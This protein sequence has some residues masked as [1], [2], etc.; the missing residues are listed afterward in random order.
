M[1]EQSKYLPE[2]DMKIG[3]LGLG[4]FGMAL[5]H[6]T[7]QNIC[8]QHSDV[9]RVLMWG[10]NEDKVANWN[11]TAPPH[12]QAT[13]DVRHVLSTC[14]AIIYALPTQTFY[15][16]WKAHKDALSANKPI[17][18]TSKG[19]DKK[20]ALFLPELTSALLI[21]NPVAVLGGPH[22]AHELRKNSP[23]LALLG[24]AREATNVFHK[25]L[26]GNILMT[27]SSPD[28]L[29]VAI[30]GAF[31]NVMAVLGGCL[32]GQG[33]TQNTIASILELGLLEYETFGMALGA[34][35]KTLQHPALLADYRLT[36]GS[37]DSRNTKA[38]IAFGQYFIQDKTPTTMS[39]PKPRPRAS[40]VEGLATLPALLKR[41]QTEDIALPLCEALQTSLENSQP[42]DAQAL[43]KAHARK[44]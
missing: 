1:T 21:S 5:A 43:L 39:P 3:I 28:A 40:L 15:V 14:D 36:T 22:L 44:I 35:L 27:Q 11:N 26:G 34:D 13:T 30:A 10:R 42:I 16:F 24:G 29:A 37:A 31:K 4:A 20:T 18:I 8:P 12:T 2:L 25:A 33:A 38:G 41:A 17:L 19:V 6:I 32:K 23:A 7:G 9:T